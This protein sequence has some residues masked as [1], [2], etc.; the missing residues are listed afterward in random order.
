M[1]NVHD[2]A[3][4]ILLYTVS[5]GFGIAYSVSR[6][7]REPYTRD[8][9][10]GRFPRSF[11]MLPLTQLSLQRQGN[12]AGKKLHPTRIR[13][14]Y[15]GSSNNKKVTPVN[16][17]WEPFARMESLLQRDQLIDG[18]CVPLDGRHFRIFVADE[19]TGTRRGYFL[20][21]MYEWGQDETINLDKQ[22]DVFPQTTEVFK[23]YLPK[24]WVN[25]G[26]TR[27]CY[28]YIVFGKGLYN[29]HCALSLMHNIIADIA[30]ISTNNKNNI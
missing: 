12:R 6:A 17:P 1:F 14:K 30:A 11:Y 3:Y 4:S 24:A 7:M 13:E 20:K 5:V 18:Y 21:L 16:E 25:R 19:V 27:R 15:M 26:K 8:K 29:K 2:C 10:S 22:K 23:Q 28:K 9:Q